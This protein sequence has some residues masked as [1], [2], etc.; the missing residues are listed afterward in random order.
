MAAVTTATPKRTKSVLSVMEPGRRYRLYD[1]VMLTGSDLAA[2]KVRL[3]NL[4]AQ[5]RVV[6]TIQ[7]TRSGHLFLFARS[8]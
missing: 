7:T 8:R 4:K 6:Q 3:T 2:V 5:G 1:L